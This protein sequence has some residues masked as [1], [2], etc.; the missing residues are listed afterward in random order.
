MSGEEL[1]CGGAGGLAE[2]QRCNAGEREIRASSCLSPQNI[3]FSHCL[4][5][6][7]VKR[8]GE[9]GEVESSKTL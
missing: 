8:L 1:H 7:V 6:Y 5:G 4:Q 2:T 3:N 9:K